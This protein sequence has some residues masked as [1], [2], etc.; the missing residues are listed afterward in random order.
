MSQ[1]LLAAALAA[2]AAPLVVQADPPKVIT[3][4]PAIHSLVAQ[5]MGEVAEPVLLLDRGADPHSFQLR[6]SQ[7]AALQDAGLI[8]WIGPE[9]TPWLDR[10]LGSLA[11]K[12]HVIRLLGAEGS[13]VRSYGDGDDDDHAHGAAGH[14]HSHSHS[15]GHDH[16]HAHRHDHDDDHAHEGTDPHAWLDPDNAAAWLS[17]ISEELIE[18]DPANARVYTANAAAAAQRLAALDADLAARLAPLSDRAFVV[19]H[20]AYGY[21]AARYGLQVAGSLALGDASAPGAAR[22]SA[23]RDGL[24][25]GDVVCAFPEAQHDRRL[26]DAVLEGTPVRMGAPLDPSGSSLEPGPMLYETLLR[27]LAET[28]ADC[29]DG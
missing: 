22:L 2:A 25:G 5:V 10:A 15:H 19:F 28:I 17:L 18:H 8:F 21:F 26:V 3:D 6:P 1:T 14:S 27:Q 24:R 9:L 11:T 23:L 7:A 12:G 29:L 16:G 20:D 4:V 13:T